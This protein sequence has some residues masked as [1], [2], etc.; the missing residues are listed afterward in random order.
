M[1]TRDGGEASASSFTPPPSLTMMVK[2]KLAKFVFQF[3]GDEEMQ[4][5]QLPLILDLTVLSAP[6]GPLFPSSAVVNYVHWKSIDSCSRSLGNVWTNP[7]GKKKGWGALHF[8]SHSPHSSSL[9]TQSCR[10]H[11]VKEWQEGVWPQHPN[12]LPEF[13]LISNLPAGSYLIW[14]MVS[15]VKSGNLCC[16]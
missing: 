8:V 15:T 3:T 13:P 5:F 9:W 16:N 7:D 11:M 14:F 12:S 1:I 6:S 2:S 4:S 10:S